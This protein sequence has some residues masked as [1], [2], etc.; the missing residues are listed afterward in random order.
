MFRSIYSAS[1]DY[2]DHFTVRVSEEAGNCLQSV[3]GEV[4]GVF[5]GVPTQRPR[6][7]SS[8]SHL[9]RRLFPL[10]R[11]RTT[12]RRR[13]P[14]RPDARRPALLPRRPRL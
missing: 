11:L 4:R 8:T 3:H 7:A 1:Y 2:S 9:P 14:V 12:P 6:H 5:G 10:R 13:R